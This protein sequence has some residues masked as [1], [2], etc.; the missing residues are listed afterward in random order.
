MSKN[1]KKPIT[2]RVEILTNAR[3]M[4]KPKINVKIEVDNNITHKIRIFMVSSSSSSPS[5]LITTH[6]YIF[7]RCS[8]SPSSHAPHLLLIDL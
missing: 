6:K 1:E 5:S 7:D 3:T 4:A 8:L 2:L